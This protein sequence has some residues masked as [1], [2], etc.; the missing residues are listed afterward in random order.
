MSQ[1]F[2]G[3]LE[4]SRSG[5]GDPDE[6]GTLGT[7]KIRLSVGFFNFHI[8]ISKSQLGKKLKIQNFD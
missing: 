1:R 7:K 8:P 3:R 5:D 6:I 4:E 2:I